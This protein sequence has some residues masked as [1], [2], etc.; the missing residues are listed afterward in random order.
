MTIDKLYSRLETDKVINEE[1][2]SI[3]LELDIVNSVT[4]QASL[5]KMLVNLRERI[6][7][8]KD[9]MITYIDKDNTISVLKYDNWIYE[10]FTQYSIDLYK[11]TINQ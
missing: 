5:N 3:L 2:S 7:N 1:V 6:V 8:E 10:N 11:S 9:I 4:T